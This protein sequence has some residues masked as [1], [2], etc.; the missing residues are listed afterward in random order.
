VHPLPEGVSFDEGAAVGVPAGAAWRALFVRGVAQAGETILV[1]GASGAAGLSAVQLARAAG[2]IVIG[3]AGTDEGRAE[4]MDA[5]AHY[6]TAHGDY[7]EIRR[8]SPEQKGVPLI[9]EFLANENLPDDL[10]VLAPHGRVVV[11]G[12]RGPVQIDPRMTMSTELDIRGMSLPNA[13]REEYRAMHLA[14]GAALESRVLRPRI[15]PIFPL[16]E[17]NRAHE[18]MASGKSEGKILLHP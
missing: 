6:A 4:V 18:A 12:S 9:V 5:G 8:V 10:R 1:H 2:L 16:T 17:A 14:L 3:T 15:G 7:D 11:V 13:T